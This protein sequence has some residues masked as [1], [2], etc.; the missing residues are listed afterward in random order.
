MA[1]KRDNG[2]NVNGNDKM[3]KGNGISAKRELTT[4]GRLCR[5]VTS[6]ENR[7]Y[8]GWFGVLMFPTLLSATIC[9]VIAFL[10]APP[11]DIDGI[12]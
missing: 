9:F 5:F 12:R 6:T 11:V 2:V 7:L 8:V 1:N 3:G 10:A 4:W